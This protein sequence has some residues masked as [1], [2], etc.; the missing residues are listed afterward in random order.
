[1]NDR[2]LAVL[3]T[4]ATTAMLYAGGD[5]EAAEDLAAGLTQVDLPGAIERATAELAT[6]GRH[7][8][9]A[10]GY[11]TDDDRQRWASIVSP[12]RVRDVPVLDATELARR[13]G[14]PSAL[15]ADPERCA[16]VSP[17]V[18]VETVPASA[19]GAPA[20]NIITARCDEFAGHDGLHNGRARPGTEG[21]DNPR[22]TWSD[23]EGTDLAPHEL[24]DTL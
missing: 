23:H 5:H 14:H 16:S 12:E 11:A 4:A 6:A 24:A 9:G 15:P 18:S 10:G 1:M 20:V 17:P 2:D 3:I 21:E 8:L 7:Q 13:Y 19:G 22:F